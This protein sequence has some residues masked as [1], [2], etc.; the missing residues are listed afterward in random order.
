MNNYT[1]KFS[2]EEIAGDWTLSKSDLE[3]LQTVSKTYQ[4]YVAIQICS[5]RLEGS[6]FDSI[7]NLSPH[8]INYL[9]SQIGLP[10][11]LF[12][13]EPTRRATRSGYHQQI[14]T[15]L[16]FK[17]YDQ[18]IQNEFEEWVT[19]KAIEGLLPEDILNLAEEYLL[20]WKIVVPG[21]TTL[22]RPIRSLC[23]EAHSKIF[24]TI[25]EQISPQLKK[26]LNDILVS[27]DSQTSFFAKLKESPPSATITSLKTYLERYKKLEE[28]TLEQFDLSKFSSSFTDYLFRL[29]KYY[30]ASKI[31]RFN[32]HKR[33]TLLICFLLE[34]RKELLDNIVKMHDQYVL[35]ISRKNRNLYEKKHRQI[36]KKNN[37]A[38]ETMLKAAKMLVDPQS[39]TPLNREDI[40]E[41]IG[42]ERLR[43]S[44]NDLNE[45]KYL[46]ERGYADLLVSYYPSLRKY[47]SAFIE[48]PFEAEEGNEDL[49]I[50]VKLIRQMDSGQLTNLPEDAPISFVPKELRRILKKGN[51]KINRNVWE[52]GLALAIKENMRSGNLYI[53]KSKQYIS[54]WKMIL[55]NRKWKESREEI[56]QNLNQPNPENAALSLE[57][58]FHKAIKESKIQFKN[59]KFARIENGKLKLGRDKKTDIPNQVKKLQ[60]TIDSSLPMIRIENLL[61]EV[62][63]EIGFTKHFIPLQKHQSRPEHFYKTLISAILS[64]ATNL[65]IVAMSS[66]VEDISIDMLRHTLKSYVREETLKNANAEIVNRHH[67]LPISSIYGEGEISSSDAQRFRLRADSLL[68]SY[69]PRYYGYYD[70]AI[71]IYT[72]VSDQYSVFNTKVISCSPREA[73]YVLDGLLENNTILKPKAHTTDTHGYTEIIFALCHLLGFYFMPRIRDLKKQQLYKI[74]K[75]Y[76]ADKF[77]PLMKKSVNLNL[78]AEQWD[79]MIRVAVSLKNKT[80]PAHIIVERLMN[81]SSPSDRLS[82]AFTNLGRLIKTQYIIRY[83]SDPELRRTVRF[84][85]N[86]GEYRHKL[87]RW[88]FF[89]NQGTFNTPD[90][91]E[92]MNKASCLSL[93]S[94]CIL[95]WNTVKIGSIIDELKRQDQEVDMEALSHISLLPHKH[96]LPQGTY[97]VESRK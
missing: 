92:I 3:H 76:N 39:D 64:Q 38:V 13:D 90:Y 40:V 60:A 69:Y 54:F 57:T 28:I 50:A 88:I 97:F 94:N 63:N 82:Q 35:D 6:F 65:G 4:L 10:P 20:Q 66:S 80:A 16:G 12:V 42:E 62:D 58:Q 2:D 73:L 23:L 45:Y 71:G 55:D 53:A 34:A 95:Y 67:K 31:K 44:I 25:Y 59:D 46:E 41:F 1:R 68:A 26:T 29:A 14:L 5:I 19:K 17:K 30:N 27:E 96:V 89:A 47:F 72:H 36:R 81:N 33:L 52:M 43:E 79:A 83:M 86:R 37:R 75:N 70:K 15:F 85:L 78:I 11:P 93:V 61:M 74:N 24:E 51:G 32:K 48:L 21:I 84:Q 7:Q 18:K 77:T 8:I 56:Y 49:I 22:E 87:P 91:E 9:T